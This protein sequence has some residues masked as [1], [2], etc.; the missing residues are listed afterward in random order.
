MRSPSYTDTTVRF[1]LPG[2]VRRDGPHDFGQHPA[3]EEPNY[4]S[5][6]LPGLP[7]LSDQMD[8]LQSS[9]FDPP[10]AIPELFSETQ[11]SSITEVRT[12]DR[13]EISSLENTS[14][15]TR[16]VHSDWRESQTTLRGIPSDR[17]AV[18]TVLTR[19]DSGGTESVSEVLPREVPVV[20]RH[21]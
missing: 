14:R 2:C 1:E 16:R 9:C 10:H 8:R 15:G 20:E 7:T 13:P 18:P 3:S 6:S 21:P 4:H 17:D 5:N 19:V 11:E 12:S